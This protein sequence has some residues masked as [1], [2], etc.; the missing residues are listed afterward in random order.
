ML[1]II[2]AA[3]FLQEGV[4]LTKGIGVVLIAVGTFLMI[5]KKQSSGETKAPHGCGMR[6]VRLCLPV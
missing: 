1:T 3:I 6:W 5:E 4:S 2:L